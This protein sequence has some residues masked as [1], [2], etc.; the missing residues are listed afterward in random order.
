MLFGMLQAGL[1]LWRRC[2][3]KV[4]LVIPTLLGS[5]RVERRQLVAKGRRRREARRIGCGCGHDA[6]SQETAVMRIC[7]RG[8]TEFLLRVA[9]GSALRCGQRRFWLPIDGADLTSVFEDLR[10]GFEPVVLEILHRRRNIVH[11][12]RGSA[13]IFNAC[14]LVNQAVPITHELRTMAVARPLLKHRVGPSCL[15]GAS[16]RQ[17][18]PARVS[19]LMRW[20]GVNSLSFCNHPPKFFLLPNKNYCGLLTDQIFALLFVHLIKMVLAS[21]P[22]I[23]S[24]IPGVARLVRQLRANP[25]YELEG[26]FG[27]FTSGKFG[28]GITRGEMDRIMEMLQTSSHITHDDEW[29]EEQDI[30]YE[31]NGTHYRT[32]CHYDNTSMRVQ[33]TT[34]VK[35]NID[36]ET[37]LYDESHL[38]AQGPFDMRISLKSEETVTPP[39]VAVS[40]TLVRIKQRRRFLIGDGTWAFDFAMSWSAP[41]KTLAEQKQSEQ[42]PMFEVE[43]ELIEVARYLEKNASDEYVAAS[44]L[45]KLYDLLPKPAFFYLPM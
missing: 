28:A 36:S 29:Y 40:T 10:R 1:V 8:L 31:Y 7:A 30:F 19:W 34:V 14:F 39:P 24:C 13:H 17:V 12:R 20:V 21:Y 45:L 3:H 32:R 11:C 43:C 22:H 23:S 9:H 15:L 33:A 16:M 27:K 4:L 6:L 44:L 25:S 38:D 42:D 41:T 26:R 37:L 18:V 35:T 5:V 2:D